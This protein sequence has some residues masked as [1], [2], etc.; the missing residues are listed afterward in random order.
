MKDEEVTTS[1]EDDT[2]VDEDEDEDED[3]DEPEEKPRTESASKA[4][5]SVKSTPKPARTSGTP[6]SATKAGPSASS[7]ALVGVAALAV[8]AAGGW[9]GH[10]AR[11]NAAIR[12]ES[13]PAAA[14]SGKAAGPCGAWEQ[15]IC[16]SG[17][18]QSAAC[19][20]AKVATS[21]LTPS[22]C[23]AALAAIP[24]TLA[25]I[26]TAR[27]S[28][29]TLTEK[30]C[31]DLPPGSAT[32]QMVKE[33]TVRF[34]GERCGEMLKNYE[35][36]LAEVKSIDQQGGL[37]MGGMPQGMPHGMPQGMPPG[38]PQ[39]M[40]PGMPQGMPPG[41]PHGTPPSGTPPSTPGPAHP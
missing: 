41:M 19:Q 7:L 2:E 32:C 35:Q 38:M 6:I 9:F 37:P 28:C 18:D 39:G 31:K 25:K 40:P 15:K 13:T 12:A 21:L 27:A 36:V 29:D 20:Q 14:G 1:S 22:T 8:G 5:R 23:E 26:K 3:V 24:A 16:A 33:R 17:G 10:Q 11:A 30:L 4:A 34:P